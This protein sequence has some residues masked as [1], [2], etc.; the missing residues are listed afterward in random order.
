MDKIMQRPH[1]LVYNEVQRQWSSHRLKGFFQWLIELG[2]MKPAAIDIIRTEDYD[3]KY[4]MCTGKTLNRWIYDKKG[5]RFIPPNEEIGKK[6]VE[7]CTFCIDKDQKRLLIVWTN[8]LTSASSRKNIHYFHTGT[9]YELVIKDGIEDYDII[10]C[11]I[12]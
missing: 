8:I 5:F 7:T 3:K 9:L 12:E 11:W 4:K 6:N 2:E 1:I 10:G